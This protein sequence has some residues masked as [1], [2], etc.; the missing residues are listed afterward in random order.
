MLLEIEGALAEHVYANIANLLNLETDL[1]LVDTASIY[2]ELEEAEPPDPDAE[3][4]LT[5]SP[6]LGFVATAYPRTTE[7]ICRRSLW[8]WPSPGG[9]IAVRQVLG[10]VWLCGRGRKCGHGGREH[11]GHPRP[12]QASYTGRRNRRG[13][14][15]RS[16]AGYPCPEHTMLIH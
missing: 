4:A 6:S 13:G 1:V 5:A 15:P 14:G 16:D 8:V 9:F 3:P 11:G 7:A 10:R 12:R 2:F